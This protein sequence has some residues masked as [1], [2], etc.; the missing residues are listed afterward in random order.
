MLLI[1]LERT[2]RK[3]NN[4]IENP[5]IK[6]KKFRS[7]Q[8]GLPETSHTT[9][10]ADSPKSAAFFSEAK[11]MN[12]QINKHLPNAEISICGFSDNSGLFIINRVFNR[13][14]HFNSETYLLTARQKSKLIKES[15]I[16]KINALS[17]SGD[18]SFSCKLTEVSTN[19]NKPLFEFIK[20]DYLSNDELIVFKIKEIGEINE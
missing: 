15:K 5:I 6:L 16:L 18:A 11:Y 12:V 14:I 20:K 13:I 10:A 1:T 8:G 19:E 2:D 4:S 7:G 9:L 17:I 3:R